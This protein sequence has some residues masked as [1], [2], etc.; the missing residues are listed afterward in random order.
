M[1]LTSPVCDVRIQPLDVTFTLQYRDL[2]LQGFRD[3]PDAFTSTFEERESMPPSWWQARLGALETSSLVIGAV[4]SD[5]T[6]VGIVG[7]EFNER[8][9]TRHVAV[10]FGMQVAPQARSKGIG[11]MLV[12]AVLETAS[13]RDELTVVRLTVSEGNTA[14]QQLYANCG[15][16][17]FGY[18]PQAIRSGDGYVGKHHLWI[19]V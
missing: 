19:G 8:Q 4:Q 3:H 9:K 1:V 10:L 16:V 7:L 2:M 6:L 17:E 11:R 14:A 18:E 5:G 13:T 15:F 12:E